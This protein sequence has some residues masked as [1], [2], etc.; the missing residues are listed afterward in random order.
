[1]PEVT[2]AA[3]SPLERC[4]WLTAAAIGILLLHSLYR[5][6]IGI[7]GH[8]VVVGMLVLAALAPASAL[9][10][11]AGLAPL[12]GLIF[13]LALTRP[14]YS[15]VRFEEAFLLACLSGWSVRRSLASSRTPVSPGF[16]WTVMLLAIA[17]L[18]SGVV[19][20][21]ATAAETPAT[22]AWAYVATL[23]TQD[24]LIGA[25]PL[26]PAM[27]LAEG[28]WLT[29]VAA[30]TCAGNAALRRSV[31]RMMVV[32]AAAAGLLHVWRLAAAALAREQPGDALISLLASARVSLLIPDPNA[33]G[34]YFA[35]M[36]IIAAVA[37]RSRAAVG[38]AALIGAGLWI[39]ASR[40][41]MLACLLILV[42]ILAASFWRS[43]RRVT[44]AAA[45]LVSAFVITAAV[46]LYPAG[47]N[48]AAR[49]ALEFRLV[50]NRVA[51]SMTAEHPAFG[52]GLG[53]FFEL[54]EGYMPVGYAGTRE[55][56]HNNFLQISAE[57]GL[58]GLGLFAA[59]LAFGLGAAWRSQANWTGERRILFGLAAF[60]LTC[61]GGHPLLVAG[62]AYPFW[63]LLGVAAAAGDGHPALPA[64]A[65]ILGPAL[66]VILIGSVP[67]RARTAVAEANLEHQGIG[68]SMWQRQEDGTRYRWAGGRS[69]F[70]VTAAAS[71]VRIPLRHGGQD[72]RTLEVR[73][74][75]DGREADRILLEPNTDWRTF[76]LVMAA[77]GR[78]RFAKVELIAR[79]QGELEPLDV[80]PTAGSGALMVGRL[81]V[82]GGGG[83]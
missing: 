47:R 60:L 75:L 66:L 40:T 69:T 49:P 4:L 44:V 48:E 56:A 55:N 50:L 59:V 23:L 67:V 14:D 53:R 9:T 42:G 35:M 43:H 83:G 76:R 81:E 79:P 19:A 12:A 17:A 21:A 80:E 63:L 57:L 51:L 24:Y 82:E 11:F 70:F 34:S 37:I 72:P 29:V 32:A 62:A 38:C 5:F 68:V 3:Q 52:V 7:T 27:L 28:L 33:A 61:L 10:V 46:V 77:R 15:V 64:Q 26:L 16:R 6:P 20:V 31:V 18:A 39:T 58:V 8:A 22:G 1:M 2:R 65:R 78:N 25:S 13:Q 74:F 41:A 30:E 36:L 71:A 54:S 73:I 45:L